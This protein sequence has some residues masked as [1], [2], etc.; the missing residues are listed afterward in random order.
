MLQIVSPV[1]KHISKCIKENLEPWPN[2]W[3]VDFTETSPLRVDP[4]DDIHTKYQED[5]KKLC[6]YK[7]VN[8]ICCHT[9]AYL[10]KL[11]CDLP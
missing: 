10:V 3:D 9:F 11:F 4:Y 6:Y 8:D 1:D 5:V 2:S 7:L